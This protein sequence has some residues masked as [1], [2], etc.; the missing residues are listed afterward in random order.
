MCGLDLTP[1]FEVENE[2]LKTFTSWPVHFISSTAMVA[3]GF[4]YT[5]DVYK[6]QVQTF[7]SGY[8]RYTRSAKFCDKLR[9]NMFHLSYESN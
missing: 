3:A 5:K 4:H 1:D 2:R 8:V 6:R 7:V 9:K